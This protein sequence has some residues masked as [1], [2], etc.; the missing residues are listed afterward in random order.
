MSVT[1]RR[2]ATNVWLYSSK[3]T[4]APMT[5]TLAY[6]L[7]ARTVL[8]EE[9]KLE[10]RLELLL[11]PDEDEEPDEED[12]SLSDVSPEDALVPVLLLVPDE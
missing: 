4:S 8:V 7:L 6:G 11:V 2:Y 5:L 9:T 3:V 1:S 12:E 10:S